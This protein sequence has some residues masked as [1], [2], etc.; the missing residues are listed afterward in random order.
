MNGYEL[1]RRRRERGL[2]TPNAISFTD[3][4]INIGLATNFSNSQLS[5]V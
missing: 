2:T 1:R 4:Y 3:S 5:I